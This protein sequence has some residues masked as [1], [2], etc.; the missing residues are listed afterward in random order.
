MTDL[1]R[2]SK[3]DTVFLGKRLDGGA[4]DMAV[5]ISQER[6]DLDYLGTYLEETASARTAITTPRELSMLFSAVSGD[7]G[8]LLNHGNVAGTSYT[9]RMRVNAGALECM[10]NGSLR[11]SV[12]LPSLVLG[13]DQDYVAHWSTFPLGS[14][15][16]S[17]VMVICL[18]TGVAAHGFAT[19]AAPTTDA[20]WN[21]TVS[22]YGAGVSGYDID[23]IDAVRIGQRFHSTTEGYNDWVAESTKPTIAARLRGPTL[24]LTP[25]TRIADEGAFAGPGYLW[26]GAA[27]RDDDRR[28]IGPVINLRA[29]AQFTISTGAYSSAPQRFRDLG[30]SGYKLTREH[31]WYRPLP[32]TCNRVYARAFVRLFSLSDPVDLGFRFYSF[33]NFPWAGEPKGVQ[34]SYFGSTVFLNTTHSVHG[35][36]WVDL[37]SVAVKPDDWGY[38]PLALAHSFDLDDSN[39]ADMRFAVRAV[40]VA[41]Y[42]LPAED[43]GLDT[44]P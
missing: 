4:D 26:P 21:L 18:D 6:I 9:Y 13:G 14:Q 5:D 16:R 8:I 38:V 36:Q 29:P 7:S 28:L 37:G 43:G 2:N 24:P 30:A 34:A 44:A 11:V 10:E 20:T 42:Y 39:V 15:V 33:A 41:P 27:S 35:G 1:D 23:K 32:P 17:E 31:T 12:A 22:G 40:Q 3:A 19:H 25:A